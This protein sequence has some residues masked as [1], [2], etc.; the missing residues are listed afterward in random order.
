M[1]VEGFKDLVVFE[2]ANNHQGD[3]RHGVRIIEEMGKIARRY[4]IR[5][6][7]KLQYRDLDTFIHPDFKS[8]TDVKHIPRFTSTRLSADEFQQLV[9]ATR[10]HGMEA[11]VTPFDEK[12]VDTALNHGVDILKVASCSCRDWPLLEAIAVANKPTIVSTGGC[13]LAKIDQVVTFFEHRDVTQL[14]LMHCIAMYPTEN[15]DQQLHFMRRMIDRYPHC[16]VGYSG[17]EAP[18]NLRVV[19]AAVAMGAKML[20]RHVGV[21]TDTITLNKYSMNPSEVEKWV[22]EIVATRELCGIAGADKRVSEPEV[23]SL[24]SLQ[25]GVYVNKDIDAGAP[26]TPNDIYFAMPCQEGQTSASQYEAKMIAS[27]AYKANTPIKEHREF[28]P[29]HVMRSVVHEAKGL[30]REA[31]IA[32]GWDYRIELSHHYGMENFRRFGATVVNFVNREYCKKLIILLPGQQHPSHLHTKK[33]ETFQILHGDLELILD[34][35]TRQMKP[36]EMQLVKRG[37]AHSFSSKTGCVFEEISTTH[38][39]GDSTY[40]DEEIRKLDPAERKSVIESW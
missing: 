19:G 39:R 40:Q 25:R 34:G 12:S 38:I 20:E 23:A 18:D 26:L 32:T 24:R 28:N 35:E 16:D 10:E 1:S 14:G 22:E 6:S 31:R 17:H 9:M 21:P 30:L 37:Q 36:G 13:K 33:E 11:M 27:T 7:V 8:R 5:A 15:K 4:D 2:M 29:I 3:V